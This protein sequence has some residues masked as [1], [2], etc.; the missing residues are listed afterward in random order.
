MFNEGLP[1]PVAVRV[2][3]SIDHARFN[4]DVVEPAPLRE[5]LGINPEAL[6]VGQVAQITPWKAQDTAIRALA[7]VREGG[8]DAHLLLV[9]GIAFTGKGVRYDNRDYLRDLGRLVDDLRVRRSVHFVGQRPDVPEVMKALDLTV[10]PS[11]DEPF[12]LVTVESMALGVP[13][14]V[15]RAGAG[16]ELVDD[17][18][19][20]RLV[21][22]KR[23]EVWA[24]VITELASDLD[25]LEVMGARG[26]AA[27]A[28]FRD[29]V[30]AAEMLAIYKRAVGGPP[31]R[32]RDGAGAGAHP[33]ETSAG[34]VP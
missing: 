7:A 15:S 5:D 6:L 4:P 20:G 18:V 12:G 21:P 16:P 24:G 32:K 1:S 29:D 31:A 9:G 26:R 33:T 23:P 22:A 28:R 19:T 11:W 2:Y 17:G 13:P 14:V 8:L 34:A 3:N 10:L 25:A 30:Q 27:A